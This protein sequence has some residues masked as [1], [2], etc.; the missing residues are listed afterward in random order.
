M[1]TITRLM[2]AVAIIGLFVAIALADSLY[3]TTKETIAS[4]TIILIST[5]NMLIVAYI[6]ESYTNKKQ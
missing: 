2:M 3:P 1:K 4:V 6:K 5:V